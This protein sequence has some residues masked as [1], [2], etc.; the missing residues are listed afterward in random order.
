MR[1]HGKLIQSNGLPQYGL[2]DHPITDINVEDFDYHTTMDKPANRLAKHFHFKQFQ[3]IGLLT[4]ELIM[5]CAIAHLKYLSNA[6]VYLYDRQTRQ[7]EDVS[8]LQPLGWN[9]RL[10]TQ[11]D[12]GTS[13]FHRGKD[14]CDIEA[15]GVQR[16]LQVAF[17][18]G[19]KLDLQLTE[20]DAFQPL[21]I[22]TRTGYSGWAYTQKATALPVSGTIAWQGRHYRIDSQTSNAN[23]DWSCGYMRRETAWNWGSLSG[24]LA[25]GRRVGLNLAAGVNETGFSE[26]GFWVDGKLH[27][28]GSVQFDFRRKDRMQPWQIRSGDDRVALRFEPEGQRSERINALIVASNFTQLFGR[29]HGTLTTEQGETLTLDGQ[30]G[31]A[32]DHYAKW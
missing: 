22:C 25:D 21:R 26:N 4:D 12:R 7:F 11:P 15:H 24:F 30:P 14:R 19:I 31:F 23:H 8:L 1:Q 13:H 9:T 18:R 10:S 27:R 20:P 3:F 17:R 28:V 16:R 6:F 29:Y 5:G 32:E 2:F